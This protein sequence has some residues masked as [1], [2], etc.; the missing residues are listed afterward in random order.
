M[1]PKK[2]S[3]IDIGMRIKWLREDRKMSMRDLAAKADVATS[4]ISKIEAGKSS[5]TVAT[6]QK[7][8]YAMNVDFY[9][10]FERRH[11]DLDPSEQILFRRADMVIT[12]DEDRKWYYAFP[13][14]PRIR[15]Q[16][17]YEEYQ[18]RTHVIEREVHRGDI[19]GYVVSG[20]LTIE[21]IDQGRFVIQAGDAFYIK[22]G[23]LHSS[24]NDGDRI[25][26]LVT[27][28]LH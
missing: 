6:L 16:M 13:S 21:V 20:Q 27:V 11:D 7:I 4:L 23:R 24:M 26:K 22:Q 3:P 28:E 12:Q 8:L 17:T 1:P 14:H 25:L 19:A 10:F 5:P 2:L 9:E 18:P 15:L